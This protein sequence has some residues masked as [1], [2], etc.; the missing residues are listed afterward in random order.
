MTNDVRTQRVC[1]RW[2]HYAVWR[3]AR[4]RDEMPRPFIVSNVNTINENLVDLRLLNLIV[5]EV[6]SIL[7]SRDNREV[8]LQ[9]L[10]LS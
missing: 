6:E 10:Q 2:D 4:E 9:F 5:D 8:K 7:V 3:V 1:E